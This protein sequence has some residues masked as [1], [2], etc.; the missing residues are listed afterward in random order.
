MS[1][2]HLN[3]PRKMLNSLQKYLIMFYRME[4]KEIRIY[5]KFFRD[6]LTLKAEEQQ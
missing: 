3:S 4:V 6:M 5:L 1:R 2:G